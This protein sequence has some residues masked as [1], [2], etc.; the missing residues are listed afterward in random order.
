MLK[1][2]FLQFVGKTNMMLIIT[3]LYCWGKHLT[4]MT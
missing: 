3:Y 4:H 1:V 2:G